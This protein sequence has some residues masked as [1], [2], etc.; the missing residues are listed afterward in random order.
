MTPH[1][2]KM[3]LIGGAAF[4]GAMLLM[5][6]A[7]AP[8]RFSSGS[9][10]RLLKTPAWQGG[11]SEYGEQIL[12]RRETL[13]AGSLLLK[14][15]KH[16]IVYRYDRSTRSLTPVSDETWQRARGSIAECGKQFAPSMQVLHIDTQ[17]HKLIAGKREIATAGRTV[18]KLIASPGAQRVAVLSADGEPR[19][20]ALPFFGGSGASGQHYHQ[21]LSLPEAVPIGKAARLPLQRDY[22]SLVPCWSADEKMI[23]YYD[24][25]FSYVSVVETD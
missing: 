24:T 4:T 22:D 2:A 10:V 1:Y 14:H 7:P 20:S 16:E 6:L 9:D 18:L 8:K 19:P 25:L 23:V 11:K 13:E 12:L 15:N 17:S 3:L 21:V 5:G